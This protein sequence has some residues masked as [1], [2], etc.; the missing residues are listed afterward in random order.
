[1][2]RRKPAPG[3]GPRI[4]RKGDRREREPEVDQLE[5]LARIVGDASGDAPPRPFQPS[6]IRRGAMMPGPNVRV[7]D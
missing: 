7:W 2:L 4:A 3:D 6:R 1:M 5:E